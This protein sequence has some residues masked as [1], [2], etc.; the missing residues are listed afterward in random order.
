MNDSRRGISR[1]NHNGGHGVIVLPFYVKHDE[2]SQ[3]FVGAKTAGHDI[4]DGGENGY[5]QKRISV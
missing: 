3:G 2:A 1:K 5:F 4:K